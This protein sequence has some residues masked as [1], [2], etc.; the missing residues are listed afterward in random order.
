MAHG[1]NVYLEDIPLDEAYARLW[2][3]LERAGGLGP[4][5][6]EAIPVAEALGRVTAVPVWAAVC[7]PHYHASAMDGVAL[8]AAD[9]VGASETS[10]IRLRIGDGAAWVDTGDPLPPGTDAVVMIEQVEEVGEGEIEIKI[11]RASC[12]ERV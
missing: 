6:G 1:R 10:P 4:L 11:G 7:S 8:R 5:P 9:T 12:R 2:A 3:A